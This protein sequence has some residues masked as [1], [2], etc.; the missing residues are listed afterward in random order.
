MK[1]VRRYAEGTAVS[2]DS[3]RNELTQLLER[4]GAEQI[5]KGEA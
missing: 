5:E 4:Y 3:S 1:T 2:V